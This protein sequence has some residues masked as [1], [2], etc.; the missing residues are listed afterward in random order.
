MSLVNVAAGLLGF[1]IA[2]KRASDEMARFADAA[3][4]ATDAAKRDLEELAEQINITAGLIE[5]MPTGPR[6]TITPEDLEDGLRK[7]SKP[8]REPGYR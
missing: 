2:A 7:P 5:D 6:G 3:R 4:V 8:K 1:G